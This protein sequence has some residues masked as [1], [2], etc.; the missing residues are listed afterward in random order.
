LEQL[1]RVLN[2]QPLRV[3]R[4]HARPGADTF[5]D[6]LVQYLSKPNGHVVVNYLRKSL[7]QERDGHIS[8]VGAYH[9]D[10]NHKD[11]DMVLILDTANYKYPWTWVPVEDLWTAMAQ[12]DKDSGQAR[13]YV[14]IEPR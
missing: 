9:K 6:H 14:C 12:V 2:T 8:P 13:G 7:G 10:K 3:L 4:F 11:K 1:D 5:R